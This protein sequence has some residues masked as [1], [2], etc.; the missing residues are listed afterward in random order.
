MLYTFDKLEGQGQAINQGQIC[1]IETLLYHVESVLKYIK[2]LGHFP[3][4]VTV[5]GL[6]V[7]ISARLQC[8]L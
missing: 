4:R 1:I 7:V 8:I 6:N 5:P 3:K 2:Q